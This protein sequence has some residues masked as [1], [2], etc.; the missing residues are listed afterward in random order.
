MFTRTRDQEETTPEVMRIPKNI[1][2]DIEE[3]GFHL[4]KWIS[5]DEVKLSIERDFLK[6]L[7]Y[8]GAPLGILAVVLGFFSVI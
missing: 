8:I 2:K 1:S 7:K 5:P 4:Y 3:R 6:T